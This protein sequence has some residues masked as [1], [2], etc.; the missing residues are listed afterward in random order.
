[1]SIFSYF[2]LQTI[3]EF[4]SNFNGKILVK[5]AFGARFIEVGGLMQSGRIPEK[6]FTSGF[7]KLHVYDIKDK[8]SSVLILGLGGGTVIKI[9]NRYFPQA[10]LLAVDIDPV[11]VEAGKKY[12]ELGNVKNLRILIGN[13]FDQKLP[14]GENY[15]LIIV[16]LFRGYEIP[17]QLNS[18]E[19]L[20][21]LKKKLS[22]NGRVIFNRLY[23]QKYKNEAEIF[24]DKVRQI[25][26]HINVHKNYFN[27]LISAKN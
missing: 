14:L 19:F 26:Q 12:F 27:I 7:S 25:F 13:A 22:Q 17:R 23:F 8:V 24:L 5:E 11:I 18:R 9:L 3:A 4:K 20:F 16:D 15:D 10:H 1:M 6:L 2:F 21:Y